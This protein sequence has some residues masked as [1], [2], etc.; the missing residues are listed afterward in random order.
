MGPDSLALSDHLFCWIDDAAISH[1]FD[2]AAGIDS[3]VL[4]EGEILRQVRSAAELAQR[5]QAAGPILGPLFRH[6]V[7][8]GKRARSETAIAQGHDLARPRRSRVG[9]R[10]ARRRARVAGPC[11]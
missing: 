10:P 6:A 5:E 2:V 8:A 3:P 1:L 4:G 11:S 7:E 9:G